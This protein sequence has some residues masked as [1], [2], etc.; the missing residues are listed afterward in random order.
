MTFYRMLAGLG[1]ALTLVVWSPRLAAAHARYDH[2][3]PAAESVVPSAPTQ[4]QAWFTEGVRAQG[5]RLEVMDIDNNRVDL[6]DSQVDL[7]DP[8]RKR[9]WVSLQPLP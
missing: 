7:N 2:S 8:D 1:L 5:S 4:L 9:M 6:G 3:D